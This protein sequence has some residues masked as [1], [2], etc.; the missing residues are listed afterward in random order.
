MET[1]RQTH[2]GLRVNID[3]WAT[4]ISLLYLHAL[5]HDLIRFGILIVCTVAWRH[6]Q[7]TI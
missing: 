4:Q 2:S 1:A 7:S 3:I 6:A 5:Q